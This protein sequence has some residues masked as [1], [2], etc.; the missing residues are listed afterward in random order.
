MTA[1]K[2]LNRA[3]CEALDARD[4]LASLRDLYSLPEGVLYLDGNSLGPV[5]KTAPAR[6]A[7][8]IAAEWGEKLIKGWR[9]CG[10]MELPFR[11]GDKIARLAGA[12]PGQVV[13]IDTTSVNLFKLL[14][15]ALKLRP[16][17]KTIL[18][19]VG[20]FPTDLYMAQGLTQLL[21]HGYQLRLVEKTEISDAIDGGTAVV[22]L[23]HVDF[24]TAEIHDM[25]AITARVHAKGALMLW[26]LCHS[27]GAVEVELDRHGADFAV[28]C[29]YKFLNGGPGAPAFLY[30]AKEL[31]D[32][33]AQPL[34]GWLGHAD[35]FAFE[36]HYRPAPGIAR[37]I[38]ST[39]A[40]LSL[41][42]LECGVDAML[43]V[44]FKALRAKSMALTDLFIRLV[45][46]RLGRFG[47]AVASPRDA[48]RRGSQVSIRHPDGYAIMQALIARGVI[49]DFRAPD[50]IRFGVAPSYLRYVDIW[51][52]IDHLDAVM[53]ERAFERAEY[54]ERAAVT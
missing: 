43:G 33:L 41:A 19:E 54:R 35:P 50:F 5:P 26:D 25:A 42:A 21:G 52:A 37:A 27:V 16:E 34:S 44:D 4:P 24:K 23:T 32:R 48:A 18:S 8:V 31:Q 13:A 47:F 12:A 49:G 6:I 17:R 38:C 51:D 3:D 46:E 15:G 28:G 53:A 30:V 40:V 36:T 29:G 11:I 1:T 45:D 2:P 14:A 7:Q 10:W 39:P 9:E 22:M 20:N